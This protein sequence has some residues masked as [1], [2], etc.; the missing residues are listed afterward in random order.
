VT[1]KSFF[2]PIE[3]M[4]GV[5]P[6][7]DA[8]SLGSRHWRDSKSI[9]TV[10]GMPKK[11]GGSKK[12]TLTD[13]V[14]GVTRAL[15]SLEIDARP[16]F[17]VGTHTHLY[18]VSGTRLSDITP[19]GLDPGNI[20]QFS[21]QGYG[22]GFYGV[23]LYGTNKTSSRQFSY[24]RIWFMDRYGDSLITTPGNDELPYYWEGD[25]TNPAI[26]VEN[27]PTCNYLFVSNNALILLGAEGV[28]N[29]IV[30]SDQNDIT[31]Y[32]SSSTN[33]VFRDDIEGA[34]RLI[35]HVSVRNTNLIYS[36]N[37]TLSFRKISKEAGVWE[38]LVVDPNVGIIAPMA[39]CAAKGIAFWMSQNNFCM[40][41]GNGVEIIPSNNRDVPHST[42]LRYVF[43]DLNYSQKSKIFGWYNQLYDEVQ[44][45][46][47]SSS[48]QEPDRIV[49]VSLTDFSWWIDEKDRTAAESTSIG[50]K[51]PRMADYEGNL[52]YEEIGYNDNAV[53]QEFRLQSPLISAGKKT[54][55]LQSI[56]PDSIQT[57]DV[58]L[59]VRAKQFPKSQAFTYDKTYVVSDNAEQIEMNLNGRYWD[60][61]IS[62][63]ELGQEFHM[64]VW[65]EEIQES[66][67][68]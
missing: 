5:Q 37:K 11:T 67:E 42:C 27:A 23:G 17:I 1:T 29:R 63:N 57:G 50:M 49:R 66:S 24:P 64:G 35:S 12:I 19:D 3:V 26:P 9:R 30:G 62:G 36:E 33:Q 28:P 46:Y 45:H 4:A 13:D 8:P 47:P 10:N 60:Y 39:R 6:L 15:F 22:A 20:S 51:Y 14:D 53:A 25:T 7:T 31:N 58:Q 56:I 68:R 61:T 32:T 65:Q 54:A 2:R 34:G 59:Q 18:D 48:S 52:Y 21:T 38:I 44:F 16:H 40:W 41:R 43:D 55:S